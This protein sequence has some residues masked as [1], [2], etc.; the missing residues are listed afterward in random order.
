MKIIKDKE[1]IINY[2]KEGIK[3]KTNFKIGVEYERFLYNEHNIRVKFSEIQKLFDYL[4]KFSWIEVKEDNEVIALKRDN[5][6]ITLEPGNQIEL[7]GSTKNNIHEV[8]AESYSFLNELNEACKIL[9]YKSLSISYDPVTKLSDRPNNP[10]KR[11]KI[12]T[13]EMPKGGKMSLNMMYM[14]SGTQINLDYASEEDFS[15][16]FNLISKL[17]PITIG[18]FANSP[19]YESKKSRYLSFRSYVW[20][21]TSRGGLPKIFLEK[22]DF[23]KYA[24]FTMQYPLLF[25]LDGKDYIN[26]NGHSF[27]D[28]LAKK[29]SEVK[30]EINTEDLSTHL[31][32]IF[33]EIRLKKYLEIRSLDTCEWD[34]H[35]SGPAFFLGLLYE[36]LDETLDLIKPWRSD[37]I[38]NAYYEAPKKGLKTEIFNKSI[39]QWGKI[40][41]KLSET[42]L[43]KR[44]IKNSKNNDESI[45]LSNLKKIIE[46]QQTKAEININNY[47]KSGTTFLYEK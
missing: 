38:L 35:C 7:S 23:E 24:D 5:Q 11:Y 22:M 10:K 21:N 30:R 9:N 27:K 45:Y 28:L 8:C 17:T 44:N 15:K 37:D 34:C 39:L 3:D 33:T 1:D 31:A 6:T 42:G 36:N 41:L 25:I 2:F 47:K 12:M 46:S 40:F 43:K 16:K 18:L 32:T 14:T 26:A 19:F 29:I 4:K 13:S 20:Q